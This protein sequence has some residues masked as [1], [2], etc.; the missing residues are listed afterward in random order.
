MTRVGLAGYGFAGREIHAP[1]LREAG[2]EVVAVSTR[3]PERVSAA[4]ADH[5]GVAVVD[6]LE[7]LLAVPELDVVVLATPSGGHAEQVRRVVD[8]RLPCVVDKPLAVDAASA[9]SVVR[10]AADAGVPLTVFQNRRYDAEQ[11][12]VARVVADGLVGTPFRYEM[13]WERWRPVPKERW[14]ENASPAE[15]GGI[16]LDLHTHL[17]DAAV[18]LFGPVETVFATIAARTT[19]AEDDAFLVC[20][21]AGGVV[22][23][24]GATSLSGAPGPRVRLLGTGAAYVLADFPGESHVWSSQADPDAGHSGWL[25]RGGA[26][27]PVE[28]AVSSQADLYRAVARAVSAEDP[29]TAMPVDPWDAVHTLAVV[30]AAR[31]SAAEERVVVVV[32]PAR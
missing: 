8:A 14:R 28:R 11:A 29:Q 17:V 30:D 9:A 22:S 2:C 26:R 27:E 15:G 31:V 12:T 25:Y 1:A 5:P 13:R 24:L 19:P 32:T 21:H 3:D 10:Y 20:R 6:D 4:R 16:L 23:H 7:Q 18:Q